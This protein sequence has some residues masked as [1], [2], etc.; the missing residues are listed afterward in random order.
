MIELK[1]ELF[2]IEL[3]DESTFTLDSTDNKV[4]NKLFNPINLKRSDCYNLIV[5]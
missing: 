4:Y 1:N 2:Q 3:I 5:L